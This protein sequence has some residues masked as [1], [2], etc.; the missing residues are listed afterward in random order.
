[1]NQKESD[2]YSSAW[3]IGSSGGIGKHLR[4]MLRAKA[5]HLSMGDIAERATE[6]RPNEMIS[7][8]DASDEVQFSS[9]AKES[10]LRYGP[11]DLMVIAAGFVFSKSLSETSTKEMDDIYIRNFRLT[12]LA[13]KN[14]RD[15]C[16]ARPEIQKTI[17]IIT[18]NAGLESRPNQPV[19]AAMKSAI[20]S[21][22]KSQSAAWG[23]LNIRINAIAPG[24]VIVERNLD[25]LRTT[26]ADFPK[27]PNRPLGRLV[28]PEDICRASDTLLDKR[29]FCTG[30]IIAID[31][32]STLT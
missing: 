1:M 12:A 14:F 13:L 30:Q 16:D 26:Y 2:S 9:F 17:V 21:L 25:Q 5:H 11:P 6:K 18:S 31:G 4:P 10:T 27:D 22:V 19:Y 8:F 7:G 28:T 32:G 29:L 23:P 15:L 24:T 20:H 3:L